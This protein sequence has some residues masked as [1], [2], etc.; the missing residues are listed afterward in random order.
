MQNPPVKPKVLL[1]EDDPLFQ[2]L[3]EAALAA[4]CVFL[5]ASTIEEGILLIAE[6]DDIAII[7]LDGHVPLSRK[8]RRMGT[9]LLLAEDLMNTRRGRITLFAASGDPLLNAAFVHIGAE[10]TDKSTAYATVARLLHRTV[11]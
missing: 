1:I 3:A 11:T 2:E 6:H 7:L 4:H 8:D 10:P 9:T 5:V